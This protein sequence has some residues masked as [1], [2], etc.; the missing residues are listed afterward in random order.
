MK[1][2]IGKYTENHKAPP[3]CQTFVYLTWKEPLETFSL[4]VCIQKEQGEVHV[5]ETVQETLTSM[6]MVLPCTP[7]APAGHPLLQA[8]VRAG[9]FTTPTPVPIKV[10][11]PLFLPSCPLSH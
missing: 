4:A 10:L 5:N 2:G 11:L 8:V 7:V 9:R 1:E 3:K 6:A